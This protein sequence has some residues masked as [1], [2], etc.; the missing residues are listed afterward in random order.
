[1]AAKRQVMLR[2]ASPLFIVHESESDPGIEG[3]E[4]DSDLFFL[5]VWIT[6]CLTPKKM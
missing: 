5:A 1:M 3:I 2:M 4:A 6:E